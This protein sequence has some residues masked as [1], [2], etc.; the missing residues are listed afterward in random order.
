MISHRTLTPVVALVLAAAVALAARYAV[1]LVPMPADGF[2][3][4][5][6][7]THTVMLVL[8][9]V[10]MWL[11][12]KR[13]LGTY[14][15]TM[16]T[17]RFSPRILLWVLPTAVLSIASL[18]GSTGSQAAAGPTGLGKSQVVVFIWVYAGICEEV[19]TR[20][21]LQ[22][23]LSGGPDGGS[24]RRLSMPVVVSAL[25]FGAMHLVLLESMGL[26]AVPVIVLAVFLG[27]VAGRYRARTASLVPAI[28]VHALFN[29][30]GTLPLWV[31]QWLR[32]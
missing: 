1:R 27:L 2:F 9:L 16:G 4:P 24:A 10:L 5:S 26:A 19:L 29:I 6:F 12:S 7:V 22:S 8:S 21:F 18:I 15:L 11:F 3:P 32:G 17:Y 14:G 20:G 30:G 13:Q 31:D 28:V 25:F 23:L